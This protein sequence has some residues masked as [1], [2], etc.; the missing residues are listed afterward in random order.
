[1]GGR[2]NKKEGAKK[3][4]AVVTQAEPAAPA[5]EQEAK[6]LT[7][8]L[9]TGAEALQPGDLI[10][11]EKPVLAIMQKDAAP[12][13]DELQAWV[14][15]F[16]TLDANT[17]DRILDL[18]CN[19]KAASGGAVASLVGKRGEVIT[20]ALKIPADLPVDDVWE[21]LRIIESNTVEVST[22]GGAVLSL[23]LL[24]ASH[25]NHSCL[26]NALLGLGKGGAIEVRALR[27]IAPGDEVSISYIDEEELLGPTFDRQKALRARW[28]FKCACERCSRPDV[29]RAFRCPKLSCSGLLY[30]TAAGDGLLTSCGACGKTLNGPQTNEAFA[31]E[32]NVI[33]AA[34]ELR[35]D[36]QKNAGSLAMALEARDGAAFA[37]GSEVAMHTLGKSVKMA[38][39]NKQVDP[40]H[41]AIAC[42]AS[43]AASVR[44]IIG[45]SFNATG[46]KE[47]ART[48]WQPAAGELKEAMDAQNKA[49]PLPRESRIVDLVGLAALY[50]RLDKPEAE[51]ECFEEAQRCIRLISWAV[52]PL[53]R[54]ELE[55]IQ[56]GIEGRL[57]EEDEGPAAPEAKAN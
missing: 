43:A 46:K 48:M 8:V 13:Y 33:A 32:R 22:K 29:T 42:L 50:N 16:A 57:Q 9:H 35:R 55:T 1:M 37:A 26:P 53:R 52:A 12:T 25:L 54:E 15:K 5:D 30:A 10:C 34:P 4:V 14:D 23:L 56:Q 40:G 39:S 3:P 49:L 27:T 17:R 24:G 36:L 28:Q 51:K 7:R 41:Y 20:D 44:T 19:T 6:E 38:T 2:R 18:D 21:L 47:H 31:A 45:D 11:T